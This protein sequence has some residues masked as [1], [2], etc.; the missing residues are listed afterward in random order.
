[1]YNRVPRGGGGRRHAS[2]KSTSSVKCKSRSANLRMC[3]CGNVQMC[4][5]SNMQSE[6]IDINAKQNTVSSGMV[7]MTMGAGLGGLVLAEKEGT[8]EGHTVA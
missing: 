8:N 1:M 3:K 5:C 6:I 7:V 2:A 4:R